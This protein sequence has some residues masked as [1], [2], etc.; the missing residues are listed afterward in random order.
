MFSGGRPMQKVGTVALAAGLMAL[1]MGACGGDDNDKK[2][3]IDLTSLTANE[4]NN[5]IEIPNSSK[6]DG[7]LPAGQSTGAEPQVTSIVLPESIE[8]GELFQVQV[9]FQTGS[10]SLQKLY[11]QI[12][13]SDAYFELSFSAVPNTAGSVS[14]PMAVEAPK[15]ALTRAFALAVQLI[16]DSGGIGQASTKDLVLDDGTS[17]DAGNSN[18]NQLGNTNDGGGTDTDCANEGDNC[19]TRPDNYEGRCVPTDRSGTIFQ[20]EPTPG[21]DNSSLGQSCDLIDSGLTC[22]AWQWASNETEF[23][24]VC[25]PDGSGFD[26]QSCTSPL[27]CGGADSTCVNGTCQTNCIG[28]GLCSCS[29]IPGGMPTGTNVGNASFDYGSGTFTGSDGVAYWTPATTGE[30]GFYKS[31]NLRFYADATNA[32]AISNAGAISDGERIYQL[33]VTKFGASADPGE[34]GAGTYAYFDSGGAAPTDQQVF[35]SGGGFLGTATTSS[36]E[37]CY[38]P[39]GS[40]ASPPS[41]PTGSFTITAIDATSVSGTFTWTDGNGNTSSANTAFTLPICNEPAPLEGCC[42]N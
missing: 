8:F 13:G 30:S 27:D 4:V 28:I 29:P 37:A 40:F 19:G 38:M 23:E 42:A 32:C 31:L 18:D 35:F 17:S 41:T 24:Y 1:G 20:C 16:G 36:A 22:K 10:E 34:F 9:D 7:S 12:E 26:G 21:C 15:T 11:V 5:A 2:E 25:V 3:G 33:R 14:F 39:V 6:V